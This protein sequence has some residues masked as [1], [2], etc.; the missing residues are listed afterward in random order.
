MKTKPLL[1][2]LLAFQSLS[3]PLA[4]ASEPAD[5]RIEITPAL[6]DRL[7]QD[8]KVG[9]PGIGASNARAD[10]AMA[11]ADSVRTWADPTVSLGLW[12]STPRGMSASQE[13]NIIYGVRQ[14]LPVFGRP[15]LERSVAQAQAQEARLSVAYET[16]KVRRDL[17]ATLAELAFADRNLELAR[18]DLAWLETTVAAVD[19]RYRSGKSSQVEWLKAQTER[20]KAADAIKTRLLER[21]HQQVAI[22]RLL[23]RNPHYV[24]PRVALPG[25]A[26]PVP[27]DDH[28]VRDAVDY[29]PKLRILRQETEESDAAA[30]LTRRRRLPDIGLGVEARQYTGDAGIR[31]GA[32]TL[33]FTLPWVNARRYDSDIRRDLASRRARERDAAEY[34][35]EIREAV[36]RITMDLDT[37]RRQALLYRDQILPLTEQTLSSADSAWQSGLGPFQDV[38]EAHRT[39]VDNR[40]T[41]ARA[42]ADQAGMLAD[43][44]LLTGV[45]DL[46]SHA[47]GY[48]P[49]QTHH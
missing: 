42:I 38:L 27:Y 7:L 31:E 44:T 11:D 21:E 20:A 45:Y 12:K 36:H 23:D 28:L 19:A 33:D 30:Q 16:Q 5:E 3:G 47:S 17:T 34:E 37:A 46:T 18:E 25:I 10:A 41:L 9:N 26:A 13:G 2:L 15:D 22:N 49:E 14:K 29:A 39:L 40:I 35:L 6:I 1:T 4:A 43:L 32:L 8:A 48:S 24:W